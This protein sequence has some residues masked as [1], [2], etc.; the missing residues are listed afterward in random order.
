MQITAAIAREPH[1]PFCVEAIDIGNPRPD[2]ILVRMVAVGLCHTDLLVVDQVLPTPLPAVLGHE[3]AGI[4]EA[5]GAGVTKFKAGDHVVLSFNSCGQCVQCT[6]GAPAY[7]INFQALN[8]GGVRPDGSQALCACG[9]GL[10]SNFFGQS[11]FASYALANERNAVKVGAE[12]PL[13]LLGPLGCGVQTGAG[14]IMR[15][16][17]AEAGS[18]IVIFGGGTVGLSAVMGAVVQGCSTI[19]LV[20]PI[21]N[22][23]KLGLAVGATHAIDPRADDVVTCVK[24]IV[25]AGADYSVETSGAMPALD[26]AVQCLGVRGKMAIVGVPVDLTATLGLNVIGMMVNGLTVT[27]VVEGDSVPDEFIPQ[28]IALHAEGRFPFDKMVR[29]YPFADINRAVEDQLG[30]RC[31]KAVLTF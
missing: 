13:E 25:P 28:L 12:A 9:K 27:T 3:G 23:R 26:A 16:L 18:T 31:V 11:S 19:I 20:E 2:E 6:K 7:C 22:R 10:S 29:T 21:E 15:S 24:D 4:V 8:F 30:G 5:V 17:A 14:A 1:K